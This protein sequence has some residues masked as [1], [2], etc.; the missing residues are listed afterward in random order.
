MGALGRRIRDEGHR[1]FAGRGRGSFRRRWRR[2]GL[3]IE[4]AIASLVRA[5]LLF[6]AAR[7]AGVRHLFALQG[8]ACLVR[9]DKFDRLAHDVV[10]AARFD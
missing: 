2:H 8:H 7:L 5:P 10:V 1:R 4:I 9:A 6:S 3:A